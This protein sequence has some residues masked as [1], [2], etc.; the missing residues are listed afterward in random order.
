MRKHIQ[1]LEEVS[2]GKHEQ[3]MS[4]NGGGGG[5]GEGGS[6]CLRHL[7]KFEWV[8]INTYLYYLGGI[9]RSLSP[10]FDEVSIMG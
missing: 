1:A 3:L 5:G 2:M 8:P 6:Y 7:I 10:L 4:I 9:C